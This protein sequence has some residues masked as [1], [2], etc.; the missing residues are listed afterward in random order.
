MYCGCLGIQLPPLY[1]VYTIENARLWNGRH[2]NGVVKTTG[3]RSLFL[4]RRWL[5]S[6]LNVS[7][8]AFR[9]QQC[10]T[11]RFHSFSDLLMICSYVI[12]IMAMSMLSRRIG[13]STANA[14]NTAFVSDGS[15]VQLNSS[16]Y[17][18]TNHHR[19]TR[20]TFVLTANIQHV[21][22]KPVP[23]CQT[24]LGFIV[25]QQDMIQVKVKCAG[26]NGAQPPP[27]PGCSSYTA[28]EPVR[29]YITNVCCD[30]WPVRR[31]TQCSRIHILCFF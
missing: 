26:S 24:I 8:C 25:L 3:L 10:R 11:C 2:N 12:A 13:T 27:H 23:P 15:R 9:L 17:T 16:Y 28:V 14:T 7:C 19:V 30:A 20:Q 29:G 31:Q 22:G 5:A 18:T 1:C 21:M 6:C 4:K